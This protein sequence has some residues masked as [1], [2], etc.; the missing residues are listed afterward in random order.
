MTTI[1]NDAG[2]VAPEVGNGAGSDN[3]RREKLVAGG[4]LLFCLLIYLLR[5]DRSFGLFVDDAWYV[6]LAKSLA[7]GQG[8]QLINSPTAGILPLYPPGF[9]AVLS[10]VW[11]IAPEFPGNI[12][13]LKLVTV[14]SM[15]GVGILTWIYL[16]R[17]RGV[18]STPAVLLGGLTVICWQLSSMATSSLMSE[19]FFTLLVMGQIVVTERLIRTGGPAAREGRRSEMGLVLLCGLLAG[20]AYLT[21][22]MGIAVIVATGFCLLRQRL[23]RQL[24]V[25]LGLVLLLVGPWTLYAARHQP[26]PEQRAEQRGAIVIPYSEQFWQRMAGSAAS[27][28]ITAADLPGRVLK[29]LRL[30]ASRDT[31]R[32]I[33]PPVYQWLQER[34]MEIDPPLSYPTLTLSLLLFV[35]LVVGY[36]CAARERIGPAEITVPLMLGIVLLW[37]FEPLRFLLPLTPLIF[38]YFCRGVI[39]LARRFR[40]VMDGGAE[41][42]VTIL[43]VG[44]L[45]LFNVFSHG[46]YLFDLYFKSEIER[47]AWLQSFD[48]IEQM[49]DWVNRS[50]PRGEIFATSNPALISLYTGRPTVAGELNPERWEY[51]RQNKIRYI[52]LCNYLGNP[53]PAA[54]RG[55]EDVYKS[56][57]E[58]SFRI[59]DLG[60][61]ETRPAFGQ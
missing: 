2:P 10:L 11:R 3:S 33:L 45:L 44:V 18:A 46:A 51:Y 52:V 17:Y 14:L 19:P 59:I 49:T 54:L 26:T 8:F 1:N 56:K 4:V 6:L 15:M 30:V 24:T 50:I 13:W 5:F 38:W 29:N 41:G 34:P 20:L 7:T 57:R 12:A 32:I 47:P 23:W 9:P 21:R 22:S 40:P 35:L 28:T 58:Q 25:Y 27:G 43:A 53:K 31:L 16:R 61:A 36:K 48:E 42:R 37:P 39:W 55:Y 60:P